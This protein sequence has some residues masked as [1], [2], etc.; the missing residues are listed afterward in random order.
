L[1][2]REVYVATKHLRIGLRGGGPDE[3]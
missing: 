3:I 1:F 2:L